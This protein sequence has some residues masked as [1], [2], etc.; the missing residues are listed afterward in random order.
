VDASGNITAGG[1]LN[2]DGNIFTI[3]ADNA[4]AGANVNI[5]AEQGSDLNGTLR[6]DATTNRWEMS[7]NGGNYAEFGGWHG[8]ES[9]IR[10]VPADFLPVDAS[11]AVVDL[12]GSYLQ[13]NTSS[14]PTAT[15]VIPSGFSATHV[16]IYGS[17]TG[18]SVD[19][20]ANSITD[21]TTETSLGSGNVGTEI[22]ITDS[23]SS[24]TNYLSV[25]L[26]VGNGD[27]VFGGYITIAPTP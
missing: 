11:S 18:N 6:Y 22:D 13:F 15:I 17:D 23:A 26:T 16:L 14:D 25:Q 7:N 27:E 12:Q 20:Y 8:S 2:Q 24:T 3:D 21:G 4:G 5:V 10:L 19:V 1:T 9:R